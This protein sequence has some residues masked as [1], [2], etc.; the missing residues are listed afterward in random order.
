MRIALTRA[1]FVD[2]RQCVYGEGADPDLLIDLA[3]REPESLY[4][5]ARKPT[6]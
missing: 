3:E 6:Q 1:G 4:V 2:V 5:E